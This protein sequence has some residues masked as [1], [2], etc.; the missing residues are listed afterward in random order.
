MLYITCRMGLKGA[1]PSVSSQAEVKKLAT[2]LPSQPAVVANPTKSLSKG[3]FH[4]RLGRYQHK[5][6]KY[7]TEMDTRGLHW[8]H[9]LLSQGKA[10]PSE[11][12]TKDT[13]RIWKESNPNERHN[14]TDK[15][16]I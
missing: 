10:H 15:T 4:T 16:K 7:Q 3:S 8:S 12:V 13:Y 11:G 5:K 6:N 2:D 14:L 9:V 1:C